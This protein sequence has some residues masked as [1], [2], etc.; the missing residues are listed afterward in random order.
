ML[1]IIAY[2]VIVRT[3]QYFTTSFLF[4]YMSSVVCIC[5]LAKLFIEMYICFEGLREDWLSQ[6]RELPSLNEVFTYLLT[7]L[8]CATADSYNLF[9]TFTT[10][11]EHQ[12]F[13]GSCETSA[14]LI[15]NTLC[16]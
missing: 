12:N 1:T 14:K 6:L 10:F 15:H 11:G 13:Y 3:K 8:L 4:I 5:I 16:M 9:T 7:Y 2:N